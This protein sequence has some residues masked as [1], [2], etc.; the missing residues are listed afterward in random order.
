MDA[1][2]LTRIVAAA[3]RGEQAAW[4]SLVARYQ[5]MVRG[6][7]RAYRLNDAD[8]DDVSQTVWLQLFKNIDTIVEPKAISG[9]L[10]TTTKNAALGVLKRRDRVISVDAVLLEDRDAPSWSTLEG[11]RETA[12]P[13]EQ[14]VHVQQRAAVRASLAA[15]STR[16]LA[17][18]SLLAADPPVPYVEISQRLGVPIGSI[19]P[20]RARCLERLQRASAVRALV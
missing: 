17:L 8:V 5:P 14:L 7:A 6:I 12:E 10:A 2:E 18:L 15:L 19:G 3:G 16:Q 1:E 4:E 20:T 11:G 9:W 13:D